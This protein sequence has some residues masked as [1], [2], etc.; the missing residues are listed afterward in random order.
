MQNNPNGSMNGYQ[1]NGNLNNGHNASFKTQPDEKEVELGPLIPFEKNEKQKNAVYNDTPTIVTEYDNVEVKEDNCCVCPD[2]CW[3]PCH[4]CASFCSTLCICCR[5]QEVEYEVRTGQA[6]VIT[7]KGDI[8]SQV[9]GPA[10]TTVVNEDKKEFYW[11]NTGVQTAIVDNVTV[12]DQ[13]MKKAEVG[14]VITYRI[15]DLMNYIFNIKADA[16]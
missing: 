10:T 12:T 3:N 7:Y 5:P 2:D 13:D 1:T 11:I 15:T 4:N 9:V 6:L 16:D 14:L 8:Y